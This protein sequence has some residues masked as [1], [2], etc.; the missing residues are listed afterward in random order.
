MKKS[1]QLLASAYL[2]CSFISTYALENPLHLTSDNR[3]E[4]VAYSPFNVVPIYG[5]T[6]TTTQIIFDKNEFIETVQNGD[7]GA[8][9]ASI[10][11]DLPYMLFVKPTTFNSNTNMTVVTNKHTYYFHLS[12]NKSP[13]ANKK[14]TYAIKFIYPE[15]KR[16]KAERSILL[17][18][19][20]KR[21]ELSAF[22]DPKAYNWNYSFNGSRSIVPLHVFD[23][24]KFTYM[25]LQNN[26]SIPAIFA[27]D[28]ANGKES[29]VNY[30]RD[31]NFLVIQQTAPQFTLRLG[32]S[33]VASIFNNKLIALRRRG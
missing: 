2:C 17:R 21:S 9:T 6:F 22:K 8:W 26:Q 28:N 14:I 3:I 24:G 27:V 12:S 25:Q 33:T 20:Q 32:D 23:D 19:Q 1:L 30:R 4:V 18:E 16:A 31:N 29:L 5:T 7:L 15:Q 13:S 10:D 11:K